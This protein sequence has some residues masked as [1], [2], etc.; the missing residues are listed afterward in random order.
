MAVEDGAMLGLLLSK[1]QGL[2]ISTDPRD[3]N[4]QLHDV[5]KLYEGLRKTRTKTNVAGAVATRHFYHLADGEEQE[6]R[7]AELRALPGRNWQGSCSFNWADAE[8]QRNL[9]GVDVLA[10]AAEEFDR[11]MTRRAKSSVRTAML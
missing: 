8:Y 4:A 9:L 7:D 11:S 2:G 5:F 10:D 3:R 1:L 6:R